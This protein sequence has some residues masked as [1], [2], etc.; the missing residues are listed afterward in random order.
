M[1]NQYIE[2][3]KTLVSKLFFDNIG[4]IVSKV[5]KTYSKKV[6]KNDVLRFGTSVET[7]LN[8]SYDRYSQVT[9]LLFKDESRALSNYF[10]N[11]RMDD[12][13]KSDQVLKDILETY[14]NELVEIQTGTDDEK[15]KWRK[16]LR[17]LKREEEEFR[18]RKTRVTNVVIQGTAGIGKSTI[19][20][21][22]F[23]EVIR[24]QSVIPVFIE[25]HKLNS[26]LESLY[27]IIYTDLDINGLGISKEIYDYLLVNNQ[28]ILFFDGFDEIEEV[29]RLSRV[30]EINEF[31]VRYPKTLIILSTRPG[32]AYRPFTIFETK[33][34]KYLN[35]DERNYLIEK[36]I[37]DINLRIRLIKQLNA[38][39]T[40]VLESLMTPLLVSLL[41]LSYREYPKIP[42][43]LHLYY[44]NV[45]EALFEKH[46]ANVKLGFYRDK[47][48]GLEKDDFL[49]VIS[50]LS[51]N[52]YFRSDFIFTD[53]LLTDYIKEA[54]TYF[55]QFF[56]MN[57]DNFKKDLISTVCLII[58]DGID[59]T[60]IHRSFQEY[61]T[62]YFIKDLEG[63]QIVGIFPKI[64]KNPF[65][66]SLCRELNEEKLIKHIY[67]PCID[68]FIGEYKNKSFPSE[69]HKVYFQMSYFLGDID[70]GSSS[71]EYL[72]GVRFRLFHVFCQ[73]FIGSN[74]D[75]LSWS[76]N[77][78]ED[79][80][81]I[82]Y[83]LEYLNDKLKKDESLTS[84]TSFLI[85]ELNSRSLMIDLSSN[86]TMPE[87]YRDSKLRRE[88]FDKICHHLK[89][90]PS[91]SIIE[92]CIYLQEKFKEITE[93][94][95]DLIKIMIS[96]KGE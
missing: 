52:S 78:R 30:S 2:F 76:N 68:E 36:Y 55:S 5:K 74:F 33:R 32:Y 59:Y 43:K 75:L 65:L 46:D 64:V 34:I 38:L 24:L 23:L 25:L 94:Q 18:E 91:D 48:S 63:A 20:K 93:R 13:I 31:G 96:R 49:K 21:S 51:F 1:E 7:Y 37:D 14:N 77:Y 41:I 35:R 54:S 40:S 15:L 42:E 85:N 69:D 57:V 22:W 92:I 82:P 71:K 9:N 3:A 58:P 39:K 50:L 90:T 86:K 66:L 73:I 6:E 81:Y 88:Y 12:N 67:L 60:F 44:H 87:S 19:M 4:E 16:K 29:N 70:R 27:D 84:K 83:Y 28:I 47:M 26:K 10:C 53:Y 79:D 17:K 45:F 95:N 80:F 61:F 89:V 56:K 62:A 8:S 72:P 11:L